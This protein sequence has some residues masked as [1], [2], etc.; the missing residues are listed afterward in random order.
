V[1]ELERRRRLGALLLSIAADFNRLRPDDVSGALNDGLARLGD[2]AGVDRSY[3]YVLTSERTA[4]RPFVWAR[5]SDSVHR[6]L[7]QFDGEIDLSDFE[8]GLKRLRGGEILMTQ[9]TEDP[10][11]ITGAPQG[12]PYSR[13]S[14]QLP[15][16]VAGRLAGFIGF[17]VLRRE[18]MWDE[19]VVELLKM[20]SFIFAGALE[21]KDFE[22]ALMAANAE[23]EAKVDQ[24]TRELAAKQAQLVQSEKMASL[25]QLSAGV[26]HELNSPLG[27][28]KSNSQT[29]ERAAQRVGSDAQ[30]DRVRD[31]IRRLSQENLAAVERIDRIVSGL[32]SFA[33]LDRAD[34]GSVDLRECIETALT[35][36]QHAI[37]DRIEVRRHF[38]DTSSVRCHPSQIN[39][40]VMNLLLNAIQSIDG[41]G[42]IDIRLSNDGD[43]VRVE[44]ADSGSGIPED[45]RD[46]VFDPGFTTK[47]VG[48]GTGLGLSIALQIVTEHEGRLWFESETGSGSRFFVWLPRDHQH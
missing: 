22:V 26:A 33:G 16:L 10:S 36:V 19:E 43:G 40:V 29:L 4:M 44:L 20:A 39:Q 31:A 9:V 38:E 46:R 3:V 32:R 17:D 13:S 21:R 35:L 23:L 2:F 15:L 30:S 34:F 27:V 48:V 37:A 12:P 18:P 11:Q 28:L 7:Q 24:R 14:L 8:D 41:T 6:W 1:T 47:G 42:T 45:H 25:G 5:D